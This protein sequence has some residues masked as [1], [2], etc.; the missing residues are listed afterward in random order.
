MNN[1]LPVQIKYSGKEV[2]DGSMP[3]SDVVGALKGFSDA[4]TELVIY[5]KSEAQHTIRIKGIKKGSVH[6]LLEVMATVG[7]HKDAMEGLGGLGVAAAGILKLLLSVIDLTKHTKGKECSPK[8]ITIGDKNVTIQNC[9]NVALN[10]SIETYQVY[11]EGLIKQ[12][13]SKICDP[14]EGGEVDAVSISSSENGKEIES[15]ISSKDKEFFSYSSQE[16]VETREMVLVGNMVSLNKEREG[17]SFRLQ[18]GTRIS[19]KLKSEH[20]E[21]MFQHILHKGLVK[22]KCVAHMDENL[23]PIKIDITEILD[24]EPGL[25]LK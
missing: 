4:Y 23:K 11:Q 9:D 14:L 5:K 7:H 25:G 12:H 22:V 6:F 3:L 18:D 13:L 2:D 15:T 10:F 20:P 8:A 21:I 24:M 17:G 19:Y 1:L 16:I